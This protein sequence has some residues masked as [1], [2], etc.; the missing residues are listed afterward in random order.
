M[1]YNFKMINVKK[2]A[3]HFQNYE[4]QIILITANTCVR[5][6]TIA[7]AAVNNV[8]EVYADICKAEGFQ[9]STSWRTDY[10]AGEFI[11]R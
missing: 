7:K 6:E 5:N 4:K 1:G 3:L 9:A 8:A 11:E 2:Y 10:G